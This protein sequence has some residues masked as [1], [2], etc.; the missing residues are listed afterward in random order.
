MFCKKFYFE[1]FVPSNEHAA[2]IIGFK[3]YKIKRISK[4]THTYIQCPSPNELPIFRIFGDNKFSVDVARI[5]IRES[6]MHFD[7]MR[8]KKRKIDLQPGD[9][10][11]TA[12]F[13]KY[14][15]PCI[16]GRKGKQI[17]KIMTATN[18]I[19]ISPDTNK[20]PIFIVSGKER[21]VEACVL[22]M[23]IIAF[24]AS[25]INYFSRNELFLI[26]DFFN[27]NMTE[28]NFMSCILNIVNVKSFMQRFSCLNQKRIFQKI[29]EKS[30]IYKC[31][32]CKNES[33]KI[34]RT[35]CHH[36]ISCD[37]CIAHLYADIYLK[38]KMCGKKIENFLIE[39]YHEYSITSY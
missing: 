39:Y 37:S 32:N 30:S 14:D 27:N 19:V 5:K 31:W 17:K 28:F 26:H 2:E 6:A 25:G 33:N 18:V 1:E 7:L 20:E 13:R 23:K 35:L 4:E 21:N 15:I 3:G 9:K 38:C 36:I 10:L 16:I 12:Y 34:A 8:N 22:A 11:E 29:P 24:S